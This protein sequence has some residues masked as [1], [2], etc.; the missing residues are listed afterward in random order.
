M[1]ET[2]NQT[3]KVEDVIVGVVIEEEET[4]KKSKFTKFT[5]DHPRAA[6]A[7]GITAG[8][9]AAVG[10]VLV[11]KKVADARESS[12]NAVDYSDADALELEFDHSGTEALIAEA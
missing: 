2:K 5:E 9:A 3:P 7:V 11:V 10:T 6:K 1:A 8:V 4:T 12:L